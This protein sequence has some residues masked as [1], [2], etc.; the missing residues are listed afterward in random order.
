[1]K[2]KTLLSCALSLLLLASSLASPVYAG[3]PGD[4][5]YDKK[6]RSVGGA[7]AT[8]VHDTVYS[9]SECGMTAKA[10]Y[11]GTANKKMD[12]MGFSYEVYSLFNQEDPYDS[13]AASDSDTS[14][15]SAVSKKTDGFWKS[16]A[17]FDYA[18]GGSTWSPSS[19]IYNCAENPGVRAKS[20]ESDQIPQPPSDDNIDYF[21]NVV[22]N[23]QQQTNSNKKRSLSKSE[24]TDEQD[25][26][27]LF[28]RDQ[29]QKLKEYNVKLS[30]IEIDGQPKDLTN[31]KNFEDQVTGI[32]FDNAKESKLIKVIH[33]KEIEATTEEKTFSVLPYAFIDQTN[34]RIDSGFITEEIAKKN[35]EEEEE[36]EEENPNLKLSKIP[37]KARTGAYINF[38]M[39][40]DKPTN[41]KYYYSKNNDWWYE[42][43]LA[44]HGDTVW[45][46]KHRGSKEYWSFTAA[47]KIIRYKSN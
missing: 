33:F 44:G 26:V 28:F 15:I 22:E 46:L 19:R 20:L 16:E 41:Q 45:K 14:R 7:T 38:D 18:K 36:E 43:D 42:K 29:E 23:Y 37:S 40:D 1:M 4:G 3:T 5:D 30:D 12:A 31:I 8:L 25:I 17:D 11:T 13:D 10:V 34:N 47:G 27:E 24:K 21:I 39:F 6:S 9:G 35:T 2:R 32:Q